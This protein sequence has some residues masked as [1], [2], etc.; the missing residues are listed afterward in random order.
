MKGKKIFITGGAGF[1]GSTLIKRL[2]EDND[3]TVY[4]NMHRDS[5]SSTTVFQHK[6]LSYVKGDVLDAELLKHSAT[7]SNVFIHAAAIA[8]IDNTAKHPIRTMQVNFLGTCNALEAC[9]DN[10]ALERFIHFSTSEVFGS[11]AYLSSE[12]NPG[13]IGPAGEARW[14]YA[15]SKLAGEHLSHG[16]YKEYKLPVTTI[17]PFNIYGPGQIGEGAVSIMIRKALQDED[18]LIFGD[19]TQIRSWCYVD[20]IVEALVQILDKPIA[21]GESFNIG[22]VKATV[23]I[24]GL[25]QM[26]CRLLNS[27][28]NIVFT[29]PLPADIELRIPNVEK[30]KKY[31]DFEAKVDLETGILKTAKWTEENLQNLPKVPDMFKRNRDTACTDTL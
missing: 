12:D 28:S 1:I 26:I 23:T 7:G 13:I 24:Y 31:L 15:I 18:I 22:N 11:R 17:R 6:N 14:T 3:I 16:Y 2:I 19:G 8:G 29:H 9:K 27:K 5:I 21:I 30:S 10:R 4:D 20:D 25:A